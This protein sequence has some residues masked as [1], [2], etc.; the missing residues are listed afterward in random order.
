MVLSPEEASTLLFKRC[1]E[2]ML[3]G[4]KY[5]VSADLTVRVLTQRLYGDYR[6]AHNT[7]E[8]KRAEKH[9]FLFKNSGLGKELF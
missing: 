7:Q 8:Y 4:L 2:L 9:V 6:Q 1:V 5:N 3:S